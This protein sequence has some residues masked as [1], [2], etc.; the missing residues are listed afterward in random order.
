MVSWV[1][2]KAAAAKA[3]MCIKSVKWNLDSCSSPDRARV[4]LLA[5]ILHTQS[6]ADLWE[7]VEIFNRPLDFPINDLV[8]V[9]EGL[10]SVRRAVQLQNERLTKSV[11]QHGLKMTPLSTQHY[12]LGVIA[13]EAWMCTIGAGIVPGRRDDVR[14]IW[15]C[16]TRA[17]CSLDVAIGLCQAN[18]RWWTGMTGDPITVFVNQDTEELK[19]YCDFV[20]AQF[21]IRDMA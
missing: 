20:P 21:Q 12:K 2:R 7:D 18:E 4:L 13:L 5:S 11:L 19:S 17:R 6:L 9:Y 8:Q 1:N 3:Y 15:Q 14:Y 16:L 10:E